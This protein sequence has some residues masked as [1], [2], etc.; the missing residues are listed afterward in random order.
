MLIAD[1]LHDIFVSLPAVHGKL[2][3]FSKVVWLVMQN[4]FMLNSNQC[5][6]KSPEILLNTS[7]TEKNF[8]Q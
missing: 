2:L 6:L 5:L 4:E 3:C 7:I 8:H 1:V